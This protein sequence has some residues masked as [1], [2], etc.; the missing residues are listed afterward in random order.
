M[1]PC[2]IKWNWLCQFQP[3]L[4]RAPPVLLTPSLLRHTSDCPPVSS[5]NAL[6]C[7]PNNQPPHP[8][9][10]C[11]PCSRLLSN[12]V[13]VYAL[14][15]D[16]LLQYYPPVNSNLLTPPSNSPLLTL[17]LTTPPDCPPCYTLV[18]DAVSIHRERLAELERLLADIV[19]NPTVLNDEQFERTLNEV[20]KEPVR[21]HPQWG[22]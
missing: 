17:F 16:A 8:Q 6:C 3:T 22:G 5:L 18:L 2:G 12:H 13:C 15:A 4:H 14:F 7:F 11:L 21:A 19:S 9:P 1:R 20:G 10:D